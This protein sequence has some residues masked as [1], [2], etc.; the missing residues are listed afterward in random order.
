MIESSLI[1]EGREYSER[2]NREY[3]K[4]A[5]IMSVLKENKSMELKDNSLLIKNVNENYS[6]VKELL[7]TFGSAITEEIYKIVELSKFKFNT[8]YNILLEKNEGENAIGESV[9]F[10]H[11]KPSHFQVIT[12]DLDCVATLISESINHRYNSLISVD[13]IT[14]ADEVGFDKSASKTTEAVIFTFEV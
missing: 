7:E 10:E 5:H 8:N 6:A 12:N 1:K 14:D 2:A 3:L 13:R 11:T 9:I 4:E